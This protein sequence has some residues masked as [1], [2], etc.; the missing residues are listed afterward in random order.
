MKE[1]TSAKAENRKALPLFLI[2][3]VCSLAVGILFGILSVNSEGAVWQDT[4]RAALQ[5]F[6]ARLKPGKKEEKEAA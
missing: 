3:I 1:T 5:S 6:F 4:L 2:I